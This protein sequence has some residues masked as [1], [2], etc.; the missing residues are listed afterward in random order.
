MRLDKI[1][2]NKPKLRKRRWGAALLTTAI[3]ASMLGLLSTNAIAS[4]DRVSV[5]VDGV[6]AQLKVNTPVF[7]PPKMPVSCPGL[8]KNDLE[9]GMRK[10]RIGD[11][12][13]QIHTVTFG[14]V[15]L[16]YNVRSDGR[17][18]NIRVVRSSHPCFEPNAKAALEQWRM[19]PVA[20]SKAE[21]LGKNSND[22]PVTI[23]FTVTGKTHED[24]EPT[25]NRLL[26]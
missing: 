12:V 20:Q 19:A 1:M 10:V 4:D 8:D 6:D 22:L 24:L 17:L 5:K 25:L 26:Q 15:D 11:Q 9:I 2:D 3:G 13:N 7:V 18:E 23:K 14:E 21:P 16:K